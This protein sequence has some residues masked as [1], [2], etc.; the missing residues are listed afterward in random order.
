MRSQGSQQKHQPGGQKMCDG[1]RAEWAWAR[2]RGTH[3]S[4]TGRARAAAVQTEE[5]QSRVVGGGMGPRAVSD[6]RS[7]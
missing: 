4:G 6:S 2:V 1:T 5:G 7:G 3:V